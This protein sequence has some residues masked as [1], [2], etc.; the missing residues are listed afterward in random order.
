MPEMLL[1]SDQRRDVAVPDDLL[2]VGRT[3]ARIE[4]VSRTG[5]GSDGD[6]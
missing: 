4:S 2:V 6:D 1:F 5:A 3:R